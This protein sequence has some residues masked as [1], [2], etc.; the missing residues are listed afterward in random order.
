[1]FIFLPLRAVGFGFLIKFFSETKGLTLEEAGTEF[2]DEVALDL[3]HSTEKEPE[4][5]DRKL[6]HITT[7]RDVKDAEASVVQ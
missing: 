2:G 6:A 7:L 4:E 5:L 3:T 1:V